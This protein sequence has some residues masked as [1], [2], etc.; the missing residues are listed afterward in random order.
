MK[1][2]I[3]A[4]PTLMVAAVCTLA[5]MVGGETR[6]D[7]LRDYARV[8]ADIGRSLT[9]FTGTVVMV[10]NPVDVLTL[11]MQQSSGLPPERV[12]GSGT[13]LDTA[14]LR[15]K[16]GRELGRGQL[17]SRSGSLRSISPS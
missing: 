1:A 5:R 10:T 16:L 8:V 14:R 7:L 12:L 15:Q 3:V 4:V 2:T 9:G 13:M 11:V 6:L 17:D